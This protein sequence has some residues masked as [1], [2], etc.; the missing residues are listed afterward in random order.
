MFIYVWVSC[1]LFMAGFTVGLSGFGG[2][3]LALPLISLFLDVKVTIPLATLSSLCMNLVLL[4]RLRRHFD[5]DKIYPLAVAA[6]PGIVMGVF[7]LKQVNRDI[8]Y[9]VLGLTL[10]LYALYCLLSKPPITGIAPGWAYPFGFL[11]GCLGGALGAHGPPV[12]VYTTLRSWKKN[13][14]KVTLQGFFCIAGVVTA[15]M[16]ALSGL[17]TP[18]VLRLWCAAVPAHVVGT[19]MGAKLSSRMND[20]L[21]RRLVTVILGALGAFMIYRIT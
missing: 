13:Q 18:T 2:I 19:L 20:A 21:Y 3:L 15:G 8:I 5:W 14:I 12:I 10:L 1:V 9:L 4:Y 16:H 11:A 17:T 7:I 6:V